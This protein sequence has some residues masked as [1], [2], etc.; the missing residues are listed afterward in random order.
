MPPGTWLILQ[1]NMNKIT[2]PLYLCINKNL[3]QLENYNLNENCKLDCRQA[4]FS[5]FQCGII[6]AG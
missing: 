4:S 2:I 5:G 1:I 6:N 3:Y